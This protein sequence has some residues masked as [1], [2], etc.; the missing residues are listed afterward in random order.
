MRFIKSITIIA[1]LGVLFGGGVGF[2]VG[3]GVAIWSAALSAVMVFLT[4]FALA[5]NTESS[6]KN[7]T[8][9]RGLIV[10]L[11]GGGIAYFFVR[12][13][14]SFI[15]A[16]IYESIQN[17]WLL[18]LV[19]GIASDIVVGLVFFLFGIGATMPKRTS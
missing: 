10:G 5:M 8:M 15:F 9:I 19:G 2:L 7:T 12:D 1:L 17:A 3:G 4:L 18:A 16:A 14:V 13:V 11:I 6:S